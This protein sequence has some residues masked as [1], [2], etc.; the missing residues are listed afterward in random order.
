MTSVKNK[1]RRTGI[2][3]TAWIVLLVLFVGMVG[4]GVCWSLFSRYR[5]FSTDPKNYEKSEY[6][7]SQ[8]SCDISDVYAIEETIVTLAN[9]GIDP[10]EIDWES[11]ILPK[12]LQGTL[13]EVHPDNRQDLES[14][15]HNYAF[16]AVEHL[17]QENT[18]FRFA[19]RVHY[20]MLMNTSGAVQGYRND[21]VEFCTPGYEYSELSRAI[22]ETIAG[23][24]QERTNYV[25]TENMDFWYCV[26][27]NLPVYDEYARVKA[28]VTNC[29]TFR[30]VPV[31]VCLSCTVL[32]L[33]LSVCLLAGSGKRPDTDEIT[34]AVYDRIPF[35]LLLCVVFTAVV[36]GI[37]F[38]GELCFQNYF[39]MNYGFVLLV[40]LGGSVLIGASIWLSMLTLASLITRVRAHTLWSNNLLVRFGGKIWRFCKKHLGWMFSKLR[41]GVK[42]S[43]HY[44]VA[45]GAARIGL[46]IV[47]GALLVSVILSFL[48]AVMW[49]EQG[50]FVWSLFL[51]I[52]WAGGAFVALG[53]MVTLDKGAKE[54]AAGD[55][56]HKVETDKLW[57]GFKGHVESLNAIADGMNAAVEHRMKSERLKTELLTNVS[58]DIKTPL[59]SIINYVDLLRAAEDGEH[60]QEY[61]EVLDRQSKRL[62]KLLEDLLE[63]SKASTGNI[64]AELVPTDV[65]ELLRQAAGEYEERLNG[66][67]LTPIIT[68]PAGKT[69][70]LADGRLLWRI[71]DNM[72][73]NIVKY[74]MP[75]TRVYLAVENCG[76]S[77]RV[78]FKNIS[79]EPLNIAADEL[80]ERFVRGDASRT[81]EGNGLGLSI[82]RSLA[83]C[84]NA[85]FDLSIDGDL[86]RASVTLK[87]YTE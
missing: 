30:Y 42:F 6:W 69:T 81:S 31:F 62:K 13:I 71:F 70:V 32:S 72:L 59:T 58:H 43:A 38:G 19:M 25:V 83:E 80:M 27:P 64:R 24:E 75:G 85:D 5:L 82:A 86:F 65:S 84:M 50:V 18:N 26:D 17:R 40:Y 8:I 87:K 10:K 78:T 39:G 52:F 73:C 4:G 68:L 12:K 28:L 37:A 53:Q 7:Q 33:V 9:A 14:Y 20:S 45:G 63:A 35:D 74:S 16:W 55:L 22:S 3:V 41:D 79:R 51:L 54:L 49:Q 60:A 1:L 61:L 47:L 44:I 57:I 76:E 48:F 67:K 56:Q 2:K 29:Y 36:I 21:S 46:C 11:F 66:A 23:T 77:W 15:L 34:L